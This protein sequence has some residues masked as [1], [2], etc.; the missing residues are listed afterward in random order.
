MLLFLP[1]SLLAFLLVIT[2]PSIF[3]KEHHKKFP[4]PIQKSI[5]RLVESLE[6]NQKQKNIFYKL[7]DVHHREVW[8]NFL[9]LKRGDIRGEEFRK[10]IKKIFEKTLRQMSS[11]LTPPQLEKLQKLGNRKQRKNT[12]KKG[13]LKNRFP[14]QQ[15]PKFRPLSEEEAIRLLNFKKKREK[16]KALPLFQ[17]WVMKAHTYNQIVLEF[18][19]T[20]RE[21]LREKNLL[22]EKISSILKAYERYKEKAALEKARLRKELTPYLTPQRK[23]VLVALGAW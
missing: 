16:E 22:P 18:Q 10:G 1:L 20:L 9:S 3:G 14:Y 23:A 11:Y 12:G 15:D 19:Q 2:K 5:E 8:Q 13:K 7:L 17:K 4:K 21:A 6:L